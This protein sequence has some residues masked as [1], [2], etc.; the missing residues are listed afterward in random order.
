MVS[1]NLRL[2]LKWIKNPTNTLQMDIKGAQVYHYPSF[3]ILGEAYED[4]CKLYKAPLSY[5]QWLRRLAKR[6]QTRLGKEYH[7]AN[8]KT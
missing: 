4:Y 5:R 8:N 1:R 3:L 7:V 2:M 6:S